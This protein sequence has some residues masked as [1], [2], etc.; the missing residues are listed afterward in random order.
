[1]REHIGLKLIALIIIVNLSMLCI[2]V[3]PDRN[4]DFVNGFESIITRFSG[5]DGTPESPL[6]ITNITEFQNISAF[7]YLYFILMNDIN[8]SETISWNGG[9]GFEPIAPDKNSY[10]Q[11]HDGPKFNGTFEGN[12]FS[13]KGVWI[14][15]STSRDYLSLFG[16]IGKT[17]R[18]CNLTIENIYIGRSDYAGS[19]SGYN[20]GTIINC[21]ASGEI[22]ATYSYLGGMVGENHGLI[23]GCSSNATV[24]G[25]SKIGGLVGINRGQILNSHSISNV[26]GNNYY[27]AGFIGNNYGLVQDCYF[28]GNVAGNREEDAFIAMN[29]GEVRNSFYCINL[30]TLNGQVPH[31]PYGIYQHHFKKWMENGL[32]LDVDDYL[33]KIPV[34][35]QYIISCKEDLCNMMPFTYLGLKFKQT[36]DIDLSQM[37]HFNIPGFS[38]IEYDG[39]DHTISLITIF[40]PY[41]DGIG[42]FGTLSEGSV[43]KNLVLKDVDISGFDYTGGLVG[44]CHGTIKDC[45]MQGFPSGKKYVGGIAGYVKDGS[46]INCEASGYVAGIES[47]GGL[48]GGNYN[49]TVAGSRSDTQINGEGNYIGGLIGYNEPL[50]YWKGLNKVRTVKR[51][52]SSGSVTGVER[53]GGLIGW[54]FGLVDWCNSDCEVGGT[55]SVGGLIGENSYGKVGFSFFKGDVEGTGNFVG[56]IV[57]RNNNARVTNSY[58]TGGVQGKNYVGGL[59]GTNSEGD[60]EL[61]TAH[62]LVDGL[63]F[64]GGLVGGNS[65][66]DINNSYSTGHVTGH[67]GVGGLIGSD[68]RSRIKFCYS[69]G[70]VEGAEKVGGLIGSCY[71]EDHDVTGCFY[72]IDTS[73][74]STSIGGEG[75]TT[76]QMKEVVTYKIPGWDFLNT[77]AIEGGK[78]RPFL[79]HLDYS[80]MIVGVNQPIA[81]VLDRYVIDYNI[82]ATFGGLPS[83]YEWKLVTNAGTW[84]IINSE[85]ILSG[86]PRM[87]TE[88]EYSINITISAASMVFT[89]NQFTLTVVDLLDTLEITTKPFEKILEDD[90]YYLEFEVEDT[91]PDPKP[92][93]WNMETNANFLHFLASAAI[94][95]GDP[96]ND[97]VGT[98]W[99][100]ISVT[101]GIER[102]TSVNFTLIVENVN[103]NPIILTEMI[104]SSIWG[105][106]FSHRMKGIDFD[107]TN[108]TLFWSLDSNASFIDLD[109][110]TG[111]LT[112]NPGENEVGRY[113]INVTLKDGNG[114]YDSGNFSFSV[115]DLDIVPGSIDENNTYHVFEDTM[116]NISLQDFFPYLDIYSPEYMI[117]SSANLTVNISKCNITIISA[118]NWNGY[119]NITVK[120]VYGRL[121]MII[122]LEIMIVGV[123][124]PPQDLQIVSKSRFENER[125]QV[126]SCILS[127]PD[128][129][130]GD[131]FEYV[132]TSNI[133]GEIGNGKNINVTLVRG[134][135]LITLAVSD[136]G[137][138]MN[139]TSR[140]VEVFYPVIPESSPEK[141]E[142]EWM[143]FIFG[144]IGI[145]VLLIVIVV[146]FLVLTRKLKKEEQGL[147]KVDPTEGSTSFEEELR[148]ID[149]L[150]GDEKISVEQKPVPKPV[151]IPEPEK[152]IFGSYTTSPEQYENDETSSDDMA[153]SPPDT[154]EG[155]WIDI[156]DGVDPAEE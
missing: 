137:G 7:P 148:L 150:V 40:S 52:T 59:I 145:M 28:Y 126:F 86:T 15:M 139:S 142:N 33:S 46:I 151:P 56:G 119:E 36:K 117:N 78:N 153:L 43:I 88:G 77:W 102:N 9:E 41:L 108:D 58:S 132:W 124:D 141:E 68:S 21:H 35:G 140:V 90:H 122:E 74:Q 67:S 32:A 57:G 130:Y 111:N 76:V 135:H 37:N 39:D 96:S 51:C 149:S 3:E 48:I 144:G 92:L 12:G 23:S 93:L 19:I 4:V 103:D 80:S 22:N 66:G 60:I 16:Y 81:Y 110:L 50:E 114:G 30:T 101:D 99:I 112:C 29:T 91:G 55:T 6:Q 154:Q 106:Q 34:T 95:E 72:D 134:I 24:S 2:I 94:L 121:E 14:N 49:G 115:M 69:S 84:M 44:K 25:S 123:N 105:L 47:V 143:I 118:P 128:M 120:A 83:T 70:K 8:G 116:L 54:N 71:H 87:G 1:M 45:S 53:V 125:T 38:A 27:T 89:Y 136:S 17:G 13:V 10:T 61:S 62:G 65:Y 155:V 146:T 127:D 11:K 98:Y 152:D 109:I 100:N 64:I 73:G 26:T 97:D 42:L 113:W 138:L 20:D 31:S 63:D 79:Q 75:K 18:V 156:D 5:G 82:S 133:T 107:P 131:S 147:T 129:E 104:P 85:G